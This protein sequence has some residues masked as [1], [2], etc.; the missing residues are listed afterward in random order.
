MQRGFF[1]HLQAYGFIGESRQRCQS[2]C[3]I[4]RQDRQSFSSLSDHMQTHLQDLLQP[5]K[6]ADGGRFRLAPEVCQGLLISLDQQR[7]AIV[8]P[9]LYLRHIYRHCM[10][11]RP[12]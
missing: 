7:R 9:R 10:R 12:L 2:G 6:R 1:G 8:D 11:L 5:L 4:I 3:L